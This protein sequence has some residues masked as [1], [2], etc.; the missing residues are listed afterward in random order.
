MTT[1]RFTGARRAPGTCTPVT[2]RVAKTSECPTGMKGCDRRPSRVSEPTTGVGAGV[3]VSGGGGLGAGMGAGVSGR[4]DGAG[5]VRGSPTTTAVSNRAVASPRKAVV[6]FMGPV[7]RASLADNL[8]PRRPRRL[9]NRIN[10]MGL[11]AQ[12][13]VHVG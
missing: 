4:G 7:Q 1:A 12:G 6:R 5:G 8:T 3:A 2:S 13:W 11:C 10:G 9:L